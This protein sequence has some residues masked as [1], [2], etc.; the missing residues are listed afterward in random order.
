MKSFSPLEERDICVVCKQASK[1]YLLERTAFSYFSRR[2]QSVIER[3]PYEKGLR[4]SDRKKENIE[5][6]EALHHRVTDSAVQDQRSVRR[7]ASCDAIA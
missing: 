4:Q 5:D 6:K 3:A 1:P 2:Q 7:N